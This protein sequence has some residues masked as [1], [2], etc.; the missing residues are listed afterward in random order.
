MAVADW[1]YSKAYRQFSSNGLATYLSALMQQMTSLI[2]CTISASMSE[3]TRWMRKFSRYRA[4]FN[5]CSFRNESPHPAPR[6]GAR[7]GAEESEAH[8]LA[9]PKLLQKLFLAVFGRWALSTAI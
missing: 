4:A 7:R 6:K 8:G 1:T 9:F 5:K 3:G 2:D